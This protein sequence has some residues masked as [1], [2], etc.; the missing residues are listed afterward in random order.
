[1]QYAAARPVAMETAVQEEDSDRTA[2]TLL[3]DVSGQYVRM[4]ENGSVMADGQEDDLSSVWVVKMNGNNFNLENAAF[5]EHFLVVANYKNKTILQGHNTSE[6][7]TSRSVEGGSEETVDLGS[8]TLLQDVEEMDEELA[9]FENWSIIFTHIVAVSFR[10]E[11]G[12]GQ[13]CFL[14]F[15]SLGYPVEDF[16]N[17]AAVDPPAHIQ[18][19]IRR[20]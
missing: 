5:P 19:D 15:D 17:V 7:L 2:F 8:A 16:C 3:S 20:E 18:V 13:E 10:I 14:A 11:I 4:L 6:A 12:E 1:M 9:F